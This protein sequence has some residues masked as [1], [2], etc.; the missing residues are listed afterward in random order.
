MFFH[1]VLLLWLIMDQMIMW[2]IITSLRFG[3][4]QIQWFFVVANHVMT[5]K[6]SDNINAGVPTNKQNLIDFIFPRPLL[7]WFLLNVFIVIRFVSKLCY[8]LFPRVSRI[9]AMPVMEN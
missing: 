2:S 1:V 5:T 9:D 8:S 4:I 7:F 6:K 3:E